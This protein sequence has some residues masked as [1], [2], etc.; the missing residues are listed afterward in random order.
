[1]LEAPTG[2]DYPKIAWRI[3]ERNEFAFL[4]QARLI[5]GLGDVSQHDSSARGIRK[6]N[7]EEFVR[8]FETTLPLD[9]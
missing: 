7:R 4:A 5:I 6:P 8:G 9:L 2:N 1:M 3:P